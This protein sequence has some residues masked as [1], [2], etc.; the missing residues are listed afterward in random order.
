MYYKNDLYDIAKTR[1]LKDPPVGVVSK[2][3]TGAPSIRV[4]RFE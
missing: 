2:K 3:S 4:K 1:N